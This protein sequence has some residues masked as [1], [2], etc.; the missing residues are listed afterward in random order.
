MAI[1]HRTG[2]SATVID[3]PHPHTLSHPHSMAHPRRPD[4]G[5]SVGKANRR[6]SSA[7]LI[8]DHQTEIAAFATLFVNSRRRYADPAYGPNVAA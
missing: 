7:S 5:R 1:G 4:H 6:L 3:L 2:W 8:Q